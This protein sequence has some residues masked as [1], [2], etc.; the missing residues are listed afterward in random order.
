MNIQTKGQALTT[1][2]ILNGADKF[3]AFS[4]H[5]F[6]ATEIKKIMREDGK[7]VM[8]AELDFN[9][10]ILM[11]AGTTETYAP[12][13]AGMFINVDDADLRYRLA[14]EAGASSIAVPS[15]LEYGRSCGVLDP[16]GNTWWMT[17]L[18]S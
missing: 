12:M 3:I 9:G 8:H 6:E 2:L 17:S 14:L 13:P 16:F 4:M 15:D 7:T 1:Y 11:L 18:T 5:V 10:T